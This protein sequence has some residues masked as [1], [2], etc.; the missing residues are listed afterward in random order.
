SRRL[1]RIVD[2]L[3]PGTDLAYAYSSS[4]GA[5]LVGH[6]DKPRIMHFGELD[7]DKWSQYAERAEFPMN[8]VYRREARTLLEF[9]RRIANSFSENVLCTPLEQ[10]IF[11]E[12]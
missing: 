10:Q 4:M 6:A 11:Q 5:F 9:E 7:S 8:A 1:Q 2:R 3:M 12:R